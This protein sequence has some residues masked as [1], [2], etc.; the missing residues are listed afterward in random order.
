MHREVQ[1][2]PKVTWPR[3]ILAGAAGPEA[4]LLWVAQVPQRFNMNFFDFVL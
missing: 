2:M 1:D 4:R 3:S